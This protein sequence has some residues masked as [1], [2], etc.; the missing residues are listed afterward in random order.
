MKLKLYTIIWYTNSHLYI[1]Q[2]ME[3]KCWEPFS[4]HCLDNDI[5]FLNFVFVAIRLK[6]KKREEK[7]HYNTKTKEKTQW[8]AKA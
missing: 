4:F 5:T 8:H 2:K 1:I 3:E 7:A 6:H